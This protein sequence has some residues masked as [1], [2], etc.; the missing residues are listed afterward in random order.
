MNSDFTHWFRTPRPF[1]TKTNHC[2]ENQW[3]LRPSHPGSYIWL[4]LLQFWSDYLKSEVLTRNHRIT[5]NLVA[6]IHLFIIQDDGTVLWTNKNGTSWNKATLWLNSTGFLTVVRRS[7]LNKWTLEK[8]LRSWNTRNTGFIAK[9][10]WGSVVG[11]ITT[12]LQL[13]SKMERSSNGTAVNAQP[14]DIWQLGWGK[15]RHIVK[16]TELTTGYNSGE[17]LGLIIARVRPG[18]PVLSFSTKQLA[19]QPR[20]S[21]ANVRHENFYWA[22]QRL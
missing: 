22:E 16:S 10:F 18:A 21:I 1:L 13:L 9:V 3:S 17:Q 4:Y 12:Q 6:S 8:H 20:S 15:T 11:G 2:S 19:N 5:N 14:S 7:S